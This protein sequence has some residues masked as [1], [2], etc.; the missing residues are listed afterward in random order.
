MFCNA[1]L[2]ILEQTFSIGWRKCAQSSANFIENRAKDAENGVLSAQNIGLLEAKHP[3]FLCKTSVLLPREVR[4]F[5][6]FCRENAK[7]QGKRAEKTM[8][9]ILLYSGLMKEVVA[10]EGILGAITVPIYI[11]KT[12]RKHTSEK[13]HTTRRRNGHS[14]ALT[15]KTWGHAPR[16]ARQTPATHW[17]ANAHRKGWIFILRFLAK[18]K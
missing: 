14:G 12:T 17:R 5:C 10:F 13:L 3:Y 9:R 4:V 8:V 11:C 2:S 7:K 1:W 6:F 16:T 15:T 18:P